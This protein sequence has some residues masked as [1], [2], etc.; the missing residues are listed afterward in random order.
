MRREV[1]KFRILLDLDGP[2]ARWSVGLFRLYGR[3]DLTERDV[4]AWDGALDVLGIAYDEMW[5]KVNAAGARFWAEL[6]PQPWAH[7]LVDA[8]E[9]MGDLYIV[10]SQSDHPSGVEGKAQ[11]MLQH[12]PHLYARRTFFGADKWLMARPNAILVDDR[13]KN[14]RNFNDEGGIGVLFPMPA[15]TKSIR[16][17]IAQTEAVNDVMAVVRG[18]VTRERMM[19]EAVE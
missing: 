17:C 6:E 12:F 3:D 16:S 2:L 13:V 8:L 4:H 10:S 5:D 19:A 14:V 7:K 15:N 1:N 9:Q 18:I 11:W